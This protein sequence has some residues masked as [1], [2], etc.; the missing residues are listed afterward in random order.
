MIFSLKIGQ[1][2]VVRDPQAPSPAAGTK[3]STTLP[4]A[5]LLFIASSAA[6][7]LLQ[8]FYNG[9]L[10]SVVEYDDGVYFGASVN[11]VHGI[12]PY[13]DFALVQPPLITVFLAPFAILASFTGTRIAMESARLF[14]DL[15]SLLNVVLVALILRKRSNFRQTLGTAIMALSTSTLQASQT[16]LIEPYLVALCLVAVLVLFEGEKLT[17]SKAR[18]ISAGVIIGLAG[19][20]KTWAIFPM[21]VMVYLVSRKIPTGWWRLLV[22]T[23]IGFCLAVLPFVIYAP[24]SFFKQVIASQALRPQ[25]GVDRLFR[26][27]QLTGL[28]GI[29]QLAKI[30]PDLG[31]AMVV[32]VYFIAAA[33]LYLSLKDRGWA[34]SSDLGQ[35]ALIA[36]LTVGLVLTLSPSYFYHYGAF[37]TPFLAMLYATLNYDF[38]SKWVHKRELSRRSAVQIIMAAAFVVLIFADADVAIS[39]PKIRSEIQITPSI[40]AALAT[41]GCLWSTQPSLVLLANDFSADRINCPHM[42]DYEGTTMEYLHVQLATAQ[43]LDSPQLQKLFLSW[44]KQSDVVIAPTFQLDS[45]SNQ[46]LT[47]HFHRI[48]VSGKYSGFWVFK[49]TLKPSG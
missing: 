47:Q 26:M 11:L 23:A 44:I 21:L 49:R 42:V 10:G 17:L 40:S 9:H 8:T 3:E 1:T 24:V 5:T 45:K 2:S 37:L 13:R 34:S 27:I 36:A 46:Y 22:G 38:Y 20:T 28:P 7:L 35:F 14:T 25:D 43:K 19:A 12:L 4:L 16:I 18:I 6:L 31:W 32:L 48:Y 39:P 41:P 33:I 15:I 30:S 29:S